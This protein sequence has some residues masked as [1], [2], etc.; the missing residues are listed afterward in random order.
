MASSS[1][2]TPHV[3]VF[4]PLVPL[5]TVVSSIVMQPFFPLQLLARLPILVRLSVGGMLL[6]AGIGMMASG[7]RALTR[8]GTNVPTSLPTLVV[9]TS[10]IYRW[11]R[12]PL[13]VG[14]CLVMLGVA[15]L[16]AL[17]WLP[18]IFPLSLAVLHF[19]IIRREERYL[20]RKFGDDYLRY[21]SRVPRYIPL[22]IAPLFRNEAR[23]LGA[24]VARRPKAPLGDDVRVSASVLGVDGDGLAGDEVP[25][26]TGGE[27][28]T[29]DSS[30]SADRAS[31]SWMDE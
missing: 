16:C 5:I 9:V 30:C 3:I 7:R 29:I 14:G 17:D 31:V 4:P 27:R 2:D 19:G 10:G 15:F 23:D 21:A 18:L 22:F 8:N 20:E 11:S 1:Q 24:S 6:L 12:N 28:R 26:G 13:Y 25:I